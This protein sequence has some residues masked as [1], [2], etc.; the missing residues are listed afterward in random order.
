M[1]VRACARQL[2]AAGA[3]R[4]A[5]RDGLADVFMWE[6]F[7]TKFLVD[8]GE[9]R[10]V[11]EVPTPWPCFSIAA[12]DEA[13]AHRS[14]ALLAMLE[15]VRSEARDLRASADCASTIGLMYAQQEEDILEWLR[16]VRWCAKPVVSH[17]TL[18]SV[19]Q[20]L[21]EADV[22]AQSELLPPADLVSHLSSDSDPNVD[23][24]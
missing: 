23:A 21:V 7:T 12:T 20:S 1:V 4:V 24:I 3:C 15:V 2:C 11:G 14:D 22:L 6:K 18:Q 13:L 16:G 8:A 10:R 17:A 19:M 9:W 5:L